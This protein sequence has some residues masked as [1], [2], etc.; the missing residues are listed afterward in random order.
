MPRDLRLI[1]PCST[2]PCLSSFQHGQG[3][4]GMWM[5]LYLCWNLDVRLSGVFWK[6][7]M[8]SKGRRVMTA[9]AGSCER[10]FNRV[11][12]R[13]LFKRKL[14]LCTNPLD[15]VVLEECY[16]CVHSYGLCADFACHRIGVVQLVF[17]KSRR[18][19]RDVR[20]W[21]QESLS[22]RIWLSQYQNTIAG[23]AQ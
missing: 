14:K 20:R 1:G 9:M 16:P 3:K 15:S 18:K 23:L 13:G 5:S 2:P 21:S 17:S 8:S 10:N 11:A 6:Y 7:R 22:R 4:A 19:P 12:V